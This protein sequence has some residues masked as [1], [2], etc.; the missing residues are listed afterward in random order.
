MIL[1]KMSGEATNIRMEDG[2]FKMNIH[3]KWNCVPCIVPTSIMPVSVFE[4]CRVRVEGVLKTK[5]VC[6]F[7][8]MFTNVEI[9]AND[10][11]N[12]SVA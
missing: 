7:G 3:D 11:E 5:Q 8:K 9:E 12:I 10:F 2:V 4:T 6:E 1:V